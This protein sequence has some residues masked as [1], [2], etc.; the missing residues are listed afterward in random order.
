MKIEKIKCLLPV[1]GAQSF[2]I[3]DVNTGRSL[4]SRKATQKRE[5]ASITKMMTLY[6]SLRLIMRYV[7]SI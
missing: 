3:Y 5:V 1:I 4:L 7:S 6:T 2:C